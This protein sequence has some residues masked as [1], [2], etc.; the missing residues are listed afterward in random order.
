[1]N[2]VQLGYGRG[3]LPF[4]FDENRYEILSDNRA[5]QRPL[6]D[7]EI[8]AALDA[9]IASPPLDEI[10]SMADSVLIVVSDATRATASAQ[11]VN[12]LVRRLLQYGVLPGKIAVIFATGIH[13]AVSDQ[14]R[15]ELLTPFIA[16]R[17]RVLN[18]DANDAKQMVALGTTERGTP[19]EL[20][21][22]L[23]DYSVVITTGAVG[24]HYFAGF[25]GGRKSIC[26]GLASAKT[27]QA[28]HM[29]ALDFESGGRRKGVDTAKLSGNLVHE[30]CERIAALVA[31]AFSIVTEV[32]DLGRAVEIHCGHW[33]E[34]HQRA[35]EHYLETHST[36]INQQRDLVI[37]S[38]GGFPFDINLI[39]AHKAI[40]MAAMACRENGTIV[41]VAECADGLGR[42]DFLK[43]FSEKDSVAL[44]MRLRE[45][46]EVN[47]QT[48]WALLSKA[49][50]YQVHLVSNLPEKDV[51][52]MRMLPAHSIE[53]VAATTHAKAGYIMP[54][55]AAVLPLVRSSAWVARARADA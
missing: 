15:V 40:D 4:T 48:A 17:V 16:Q 22:A 10:C 1:M 28:T 12:L 18:H 21:R 53:D 41:L 29:L 43:W 45:D 35:C 37:V 51:R 24:F 25:T 9:P 30:E 31:P 8:G 11:V 46:Y 6:T 32:D 50:R 3:A 26:P 42:P 49:E 47:G 2:D 34:S 27:I 5:N 7:V 44:A 52:L 19:V 13:R 14:E 23:K 33:R 55:G 54:R 38:C 36:P 20:N 39:Q